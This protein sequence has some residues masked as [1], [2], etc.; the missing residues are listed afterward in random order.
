MPPPTRASSHRLLFKTLLVDQKQP[1][2]AYPANLWPCLV[3]SW[4]FIGG[5]YALLY[6]GIGVICVR[7]A[8][9]AYAE[10]AR[11]S[12]GAHD[13]VLDGLSFHYV[14]AG[15]GPLLV[16]QAPGWGIGFD[17][18]PQR[19]VPLARHFKVLTFDPRKISRRSCFVAVTLQ[20]DL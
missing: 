9:S 19:A 1:V 17:L 16:V 15:R 10:N 2:P 11:L 4:I 8:P 14:I 20:R 18:S 5:I 12:A 13:V 7:L 6:L 3:A